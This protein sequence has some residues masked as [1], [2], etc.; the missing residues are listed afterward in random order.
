MI[1]LKRILNNKQAGWEKKLLAL[2]SLAHMASKESIAILEEYCNDPDPNMG[3][4][5]KR[6]LDEAKYFL[7]SN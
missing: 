1:I 7:T 3:I 2:I 6:A 5:A 4:F